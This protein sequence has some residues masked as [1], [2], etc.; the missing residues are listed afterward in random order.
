M[1]GR[2]AEAAVELREG[3]VAGAAEAV[4]GLVVVPHHHDVVRAVRRAPQQL[5]Q[6]DLGDVRVLELVD[7]E[8]AVLALPSAQDVRASLEE[9]DDRGDLLAKVQG[10]T[11][12]ELVL[13]RVID[14]CELG[15]PHHLQRGAIGHVG[16]GQRP[17]LRLL[18][19]VEVVDPHRV[20][21]AG[22]GAAR[23]ALRGRV[24]GREVAAIG[25]FAC[26]EARVVLAHLAHGLE[27]AVGGQAGCDIG[28]AAVGVLE[29][30]GARRRRR[31]RSRPASPARPWPG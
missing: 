11:P 19:P 6:L 22:D 26:P 31:R 20:A 14:R 15:Q 30:L 24:D 1:G 29:G 17:D 12:G 25:S 3:R 4:D 9:A 28:I 18:L 2:L 5:D 13:V 21:R 23:L 27:V 7:Q 16:G 10:A 8:V